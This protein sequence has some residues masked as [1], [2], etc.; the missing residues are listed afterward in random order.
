MRGW[1]A[2]WST[3]TV[4]LWLYCALGTF[5][6]G[7]WCGQLFFAPGLEGWHE[8]DAI[9]E[10]ARRRSEKV[11]KRPDGPALDGQSAD[12]AGD[13]ADTTDSG[14]DA[15]DPE[16]LDEGTTAREHRNDGTYAVVRGRRKKGRGDENA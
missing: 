7:V 14:N 1:A 6:K 11:V 4:L 13:S 12:S 16:L 5:Y 3:V 9:K 2:A 10:A 15:V 8:K